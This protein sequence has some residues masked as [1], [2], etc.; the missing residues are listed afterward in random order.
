M[1]GNLERFV[2]M[3]IIQDLLDKH[4]DLVQLWPQRATN[5]ISPLST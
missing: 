1:I 4:M 2:I 3:H 5:S